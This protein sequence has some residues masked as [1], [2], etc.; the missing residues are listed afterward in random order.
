MGL[1]QCFTL[2]EVVLHQKSIKLHH[3]L[4][5]QCERLEKNYRVNKIT[6]SQLRVLIS[7]WV[8]EAW[9]EVLVDR[10]FMIDTFR[11]TGLSLPIDGSQ[12]HQ[13]SFHDVGAI[14]VPE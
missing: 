4:E 1:K 3:I 7:K 13:M 11:K 6:V 14:H 9:K 8:A 10:E 5:K 2:T 12:D